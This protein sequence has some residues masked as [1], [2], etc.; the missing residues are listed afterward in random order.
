M[1]GDMYASGPRTLDGL[2]TL[3]QGMYP[4]LSL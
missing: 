4:G 3:A 1:L 2:K